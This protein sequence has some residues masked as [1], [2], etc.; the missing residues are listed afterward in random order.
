MASYIVDLRSMLYPVLH[1]DL[2]AHS[3]GLGRLHRCLLCNQEQSG[4]DLDVGV[5]SADVYNF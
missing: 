5:W 3:F 4:N 2:P 1:P